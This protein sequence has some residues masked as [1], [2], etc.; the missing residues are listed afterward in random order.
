[1]RGQVGGSAGFDQPVKDDRDDDDTATE[2]IKPASNPA[3]APETAPHRINQKKLIA[4][5]RKK[6][7][8]RPT[9]RA[10]PASDR[11]NLVRLTDRKD[12]ESYR[13]IL[14]TQLPA[15]GFR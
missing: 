7:G 9:D 8:R 14:A 15:P 10:M 12:T 5:Y 11:R 1:M 4:L 13:E 6:P 3:A 2:T